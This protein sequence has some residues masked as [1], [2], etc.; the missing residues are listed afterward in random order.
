MAAEI[1]SGYQMYKAR[2]WKQSCKKIRVKPFS[3]DQYQSGIF[4]LEQFVASCYSETNAAGNSLG[5]M[6]DYL[7]NLYLLYETWKERIKVMYSL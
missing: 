4:L 6:Y 7:G 3:R 2:N 5:A 1:K